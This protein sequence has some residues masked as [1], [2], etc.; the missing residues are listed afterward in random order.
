M[1]LETYS[2]GHLEGM[3]AVYNAVTE[4]E[5]HIASL[6]PELFIE[7]VEEKSYFDSEGLFVAFEAGGVVG[8]VHACVA[9]GTEPWNDAEKMVPRVGMLI[10][11]RE[12]L[13]VGKVLVEAATHWL[14]EQGDHKE[15]LAM[16]PLAGYP[17][18]R[19]LWMGGEP[20]C[21]S[22][23]PQ[24]QVA[25][26][27]GGYKNAIESVFMVVE[28]DE[29][30]REEEARVAVEFEEEEAPM[31]HEPMRESW[32]GFE[33]KRIRAFIGGEEVGSVWWVMLPHVASRLGT[34]CANIFGMGVGNDYQRQRIG[35]GLVS[36]VLTR[37]YA[38]GAR[39]ASLGTQVWNVPAHGTYSRFG[40]RP[41]CILVGRARKREQED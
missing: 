39:F 9:A 17:F 18:Y 41:E 32:I 10:F 36:R 2:R 22:S 27:V 34:P 12:R 5:R 26:E 11:P 28:M 6:D 37:G 13:D 23:L 7:L 38:A 14:E 33:P 16:N 40:F 29:K 35:S 19:G 8:W 21:P 24:L 20:V 1:K 30:P 25:L 15:L 31:A 4:G 3:M